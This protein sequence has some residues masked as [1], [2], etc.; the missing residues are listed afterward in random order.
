MHVLK[1]ISLFVVELKFL[2]CYTRNQS[3]TNVLTS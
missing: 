1:E 3:Q 2:F